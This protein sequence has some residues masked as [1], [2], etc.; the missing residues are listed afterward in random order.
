MDKHI[1]VRGSFLGRW[2]PAIFYSLNV[3]LWFSTAI[4]FEA[5]DL[6]YLVSLTLPALAL[7]VK[8]TR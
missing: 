1:V 5:W 4:L 8:Q 2:V 7:Y 6:L 3:V